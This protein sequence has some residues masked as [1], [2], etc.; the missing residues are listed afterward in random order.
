M[1]EFIESEEIETLEEENNQV[2]KFNPNSVVKLNIT[3][4][5]IAD[6]KDRYSGLKINGLEDKAGLKLVYDARQDVKRTRIGV[7]KYADNLK[8]TAIA[9]QNKV[10]AEKKR[11]VGELKEIEN[12]L[13]SEEDKIEAEKQ[14]IKDEELKK[15]EERIQKR[16]DRLAQYGY[17]I[18]VAFLKSL[19][20]DQFDAIVLNAKDEFDK[21]QKRIADEKEAERLRQIQAEK[22]RQELEELRKQKA[23]ADAEIE[24]LKKQKINDRRQQLL[25]L[26]M[27]ESSNF[28]SYNFNVK[29]SIDKAN[30]ETLSDQDFSDRIADLKTNIIEVKELEEKEIQEKKAAEEK[31]RLDEINE[32]AEKKRK[33]DLAREEQERKDKEEKLAQSSDKVKFQT[34]IDQLK[35]VSIPEMKSKKAKMLAEQIQELI[36]KT[37]VHISSNI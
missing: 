3:N 1:N 16:V 17:K 5:A 15:E 9:F 35:S 34:V 32:A 28:Y 6:F 33:D 19:P 30:I 36:N 18:E 8:A 24:R 25:L 21:E 29:C 10:N 26:G 20:D 7:E 2:V 14:R 13:Q 22:D 11:V 12:H 27:H 31:K 4:A 37:V 23:A